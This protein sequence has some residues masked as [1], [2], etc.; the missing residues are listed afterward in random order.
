[1]TGNDPAHILGGPKMPEYESLFLDVI[2][3]FQRRMPL[4]GGRSS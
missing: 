2:K 1:V 3:D 4:G